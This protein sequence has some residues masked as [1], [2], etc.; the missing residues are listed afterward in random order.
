MSA[1][2]GAASISS[3]AI[4]PSN[5]ASSYANEPSNMASIEM[6]KLAFNTCR[7]EITLRL[8]E[9]EL[10]TLAYVAGCVTIITTSAAK[11]LS[12]DARFF[13]TCLCPLA[14][15]VSAVML[16]NQ[17]NAIEEL[18]KFIRYPLNRFLIRNNSRSPLWDLSTRW[19]ERSGSLKLNGREKSKT[20]LR[21]LA[22]L[23]AIH[24]PGLVS[25]L[26][27]SY[28]F[29]E[30]GADLDLANKPMFS[31]FPL[32]SSGWIAWAASI[33]LLVAAVFVTLK[34]F[35]LRRDQ[36]LAQIEIPPKYGDIRNSELRQPT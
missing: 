27:S 12:V 24:L 32:V 18:C 30:K 9:R 34:S 33:A 3:E 16:H 28:Y 5:Q 4:E 11:E 14:A 22:V 8:K 2:R 7:D 13:L 26:L 29:F 36:H 17:N 23:A 19:G 35:W 10:I 21:K 31:K 20:N 1:L 25:V 6:A 15:F